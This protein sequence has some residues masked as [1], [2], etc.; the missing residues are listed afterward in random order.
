MM[1]CN[2]WFRTIKGV[3]PAE[4]ARV[5]QLQ[6]DE[7]SIIGAC[8]E[9]MFSNQLLS[10]L[11]K[12]FLGGRSNKQLVRIRPSFLRYCNRFSSP[13]QFCAAPAKS[14]PAADRALRR[15]AISSSVPAFHGMRGY[16]ISN[17]DFLAHQWLSQRGF[18]SSYN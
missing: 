16:A 7:Q 2:A 9:P 6:A 13:D 14:S 8:G 15:I 11:C 10:Q 17:P 4:P 1:G 3:R 12:T 18:G 5:R